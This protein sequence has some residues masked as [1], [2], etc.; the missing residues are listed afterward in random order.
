MDIGGDYSLIPVTGKG[1]RLGIYRHVGKTKPP[2]G[3]GGCKESFLKRFLSR[4]AAL[5]KRGRAGSP[6]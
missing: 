4:P 2:G 5:K 1:I 6:P 3:P